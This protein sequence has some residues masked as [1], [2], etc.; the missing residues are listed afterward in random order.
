MRISILGE[1]AECVKRSWRKRLMK[2][3]FSGECGEFTVIGLK[4]CR[5]SM[6]VVTFL[7]KLKTAQPTGLY[8]NPIPTR[9]LAP[10]DFF[11]IPEQ[12]WNF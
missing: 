2:R 7:H 6:A 12:S 5:Q 10:L 9:F 3:S 11:K 1:C 8:D 4:T